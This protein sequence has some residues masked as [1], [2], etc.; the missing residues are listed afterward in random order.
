[1]VGPCEDADIGTLGR[2]SQRT[3]SIDDHGFCFASLESKETRC[4]FRNSGNAWN[5]VLFENV[6]HDATK[7]F[8][9]EQQSPK[10]FFIKAAIAP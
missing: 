7:V 4:E 2:P 5:V 1:M 8:V 9:I 6:S 10:R 3:L